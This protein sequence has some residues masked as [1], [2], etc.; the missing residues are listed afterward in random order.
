MAT[1]VLTMRSPLKSVGATSFRFSCR[2]RI[3]AASSGLM[4]I[5]ASDPPMNWWRP[6][7]IERESVR[8]FSLNIMGVPI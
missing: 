7:F 6:G 5:R 2:S 8:S 4:M 1:P 3:S